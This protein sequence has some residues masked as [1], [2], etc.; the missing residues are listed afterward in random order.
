[1]APS[2][3]FAGSALAR[4]TAAR[5][6]LYGGDYAP[7]QWPATT[8]REDAALMRAAGVNLVTVNVFGWSRIEPVEGERDFVWLD[9]VLDLLHESGIAVDLATP[10]ASPPAWMAT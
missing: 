1:M 3:R 9:E 6:L 2:T 4:L 10:T 7:E 5:G 8:W